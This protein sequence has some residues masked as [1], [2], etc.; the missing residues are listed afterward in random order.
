MIKTKKMPVC[1]SFGNFKTSKDEFLIPFV[2]KELENGFM[3]IKSGGIFHYGVL[4]YLGIEISSTDIINKILNS[5]IKI[6][7]TET[8]NI[9]LEDYIN[10]LQ[11]F[12]IGNIIEIEYLKENEFKLVKV[13]E[14]PPRKIKRKLPD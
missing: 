10:K 13:S 5:G 3:G 11:S 9:V 1:I 7:N 12:K 4:S 14:K 8:L 6:L 2:Q